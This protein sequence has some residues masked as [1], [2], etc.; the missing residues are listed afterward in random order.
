MADVATTDER[1]IS[2]K[3]LL[4]QSGYVVVHIVADLAANGRSNER[5]SDHQTK[6]FYWSIETYTYLILDTATDACL[7]ILYPS[8]AAVFIVNVIVIFNACIDP[9]LL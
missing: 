1:I 2:I 5:W 9:K 6:L 8:A 4:V 3:K 7:I